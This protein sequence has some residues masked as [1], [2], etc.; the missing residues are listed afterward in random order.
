MRPIT[1]DGYPH[2]R[3]SPRV[4]EDRAKFLA[5]YQE[6]STP[7]PVMGNVPWQDWYIDERGIARWVA[8][9]WPVGLGHIVHKCG[10]MLP[11]GY[12]EA[13]EAALNADAITGNSVRDIINRNR[14]RRGKKPL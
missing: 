1:S 3:D 6:T 5:S 12:A 7:E 11:E 8:N 2:W 13:Y 10:L 14:V 4:I 9:P